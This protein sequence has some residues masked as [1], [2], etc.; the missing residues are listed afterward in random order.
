MTAQNNFDAKTEEVTV[1]DANRNPVKATLMNARELVTTG[2]F[3]WGLDDIGKERIESDGP[4]DPS[5]S[6]QTVYDKDGNAHEVAKANAFDMVASGW[7][8]WFPV[9]ATKTD[10]STDEVPEEPTAAP[11]TLDEKSSTEK[12]FDPDNDPLDVI[13]KKVTGNSDVEEYLNGFPEE[14]LREMALKRYNTKIHHRASKDT[15]ISTLVKLENEK[16]EDEDNPSS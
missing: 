12:F 5:E 3:F 15:V 4:V 13:A 7:Y 11:I 1:F 16:I 10:E 9:D 2:R 14:S 6:T 8:T